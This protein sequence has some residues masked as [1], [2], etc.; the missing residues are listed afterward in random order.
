MKPYIVGRTFDWL[1]FLAAPMWAL[2]LGVLLQGRDVD[3]FSGVM[4]QAHLVAVVFRSHGNASIR[5]LYPIRF[6][7]IPVVLWLAIVVSPWLAVM[8]TVV[9]ML[10]TRSSTA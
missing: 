2:S 7:V 8:S 5:K 4:I 10:A 9:G 1:F 6:F 3:F